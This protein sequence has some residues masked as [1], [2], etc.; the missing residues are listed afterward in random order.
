M[1]YFNVSHF[2]PYK[3][4][5]CTYFYLIKLVDTFPDCHGTVLYKRTKMNN[6]KQSLV[7]P[8]R[9]PQKA[10]RKH[11]AQSNVDTGQKRATYTG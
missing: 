11:N 9:Y 7:N 8:Q 6:G 3:G 10:G 1:V 4:F 2:Y 5:L